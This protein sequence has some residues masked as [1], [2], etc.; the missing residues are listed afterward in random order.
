MLNNGLNTPLENAAQSLCALIY[1]QYESRFEYIVQSFSELSIE[2]NIVLRPINSLAFFGLYLRANIRD[3]D[4]FKMQ[5]L[6]L[7]RRCARVS[8]G[9]SAEQ[10][11][12]GDLA[13]CLQ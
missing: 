8:F 4:L 6:D 11:S 10:L 2:D 12:D 5:I 3:Q 7:C 13:K 1:K 9:V